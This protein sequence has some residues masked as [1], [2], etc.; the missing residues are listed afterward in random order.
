MAGQ[1]LRDRLRMRHMLLLVT[2]DQTRSLHRTARVLGLTQPAVSKL[3]VELETMFAAKLFTRTNRGVVPTPAGNILVRRSAAVIAEIDHARD[4]LLDQAGGNRGRIRVG[5]YPVAIPQLLLRTIMTMLAKF[6]H[7]VISIEE[8]TSELML[9]ALRRGEIDCLLGRVPE[10]PPADDLV[11]MPLYHERICVVCG[12]QNPVLRKKALTLR[13]VVSESWIYPQTDAFLKAQIDG[14][15]V[16]EGLQPPTPKVQSS[17]FIAVEALLRR[18]DFLSI[19]PAGLANDYAERG[20]L[21][22]LKVRLDDALPPV[23]AL[24]RQTPVQ[25]PVVRNFLETLQSVAKSIRMAGDSP[26]ACL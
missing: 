20:L 18:T 17:S 16:R 22:I 5:V 1:T 6:P 21:R 12:P 19:W 26:A 9:L 8:G 10:K 13:K 24:L 2:L 15:F 23:G 7:T 14:M 3:L 25:P 4:E 11:H